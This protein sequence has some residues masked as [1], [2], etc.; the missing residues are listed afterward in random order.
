MD[1][2]TWKDAELQQA[3][4]AKAFT[5]FRMPWDWDGGAASLQS[6]A[7]DD[8][9]YLQPT[10]RRNAGRARAQ[11]Q[12]SQQSDQGLVCAGG[13]ERVACCAGRLVRWRW[14]CW[15]WRPSGQQARIGKPASED[16]IKAMDITVFPDGRG[17][18]AGS[19]TAAKGKDIFKDKCAVCHNDQ[20]QGREGQY[21]ALVGGKGTTEYSQAGEDGGQLLAVCDHGV[22]LHSPGDALRSAGHAAAR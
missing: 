9:G 22:R 5:R 11:L 2:K 16:K 13:W 21:P 10:A 15:A 6:R 20:G 17:L 12:L 19:G 4:F 8:T 7:T 3:G 14:R 1:G 18:P